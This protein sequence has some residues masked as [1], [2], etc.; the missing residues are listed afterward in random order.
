MTDYQKNRAFTL[1]EL[2]VALVLAALLISLIFSGVRLMVAAS[3]NIRCVKNLKTIG[4]QS[5]IFFQERN[6]NLFPVWDWHTHEPFMNVLE[7][8]P[9]YT[10]PDSLHDSVFTCPAFKKT[11]PHIFP[12]ALNR[13]YSLN[14]WAHQYNVSSMQRDSV[15]LS[16]R[17]GNLINISK[18][19]AMWMFME[20]A[21]V[22]QGVFTYYDIGM[23]DYMGC[24]HAGGKKGNAV[25]FDGH[26]EPVTP[27]MLDQHYTS[28]FWGG[29]PE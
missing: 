15:N 8:E 24:P 1:T 16:I 14:R 2:L 5:L 18:P 29:V 22:D 26:V 21:H 11:Y 12:Y 17:P 13:C 25:F 19:S 10:G 23:K 20:G 4:Q 9:P 6:G 27:E 3:D 28:D 7:I